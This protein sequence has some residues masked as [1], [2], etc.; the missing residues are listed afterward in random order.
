MERN[1]EAEDRAL[2]AKCASERSMPTRVAVTKLKAMALDDKARCLVH[3]AQLDLGNLVRCALAAGISAD[4]RWGETNTPV[5]SFA[6]ARGSS[7]AL[8]AL[9]EGGACHGLANKLGWSAAHFAAYSGHAACLRLLLDAG[10]L[11]E[12]KMTKGATPLLDAAEQGHVE[13]CQLLLRLPLFSRMRRRCISL[14]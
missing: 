12:A 7:C 5:L 10:A 6:A 2:D 13:A 1:S 14:R 11:L 9:L 8:K 4:T 3:Y